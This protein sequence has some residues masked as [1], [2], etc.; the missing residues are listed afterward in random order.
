MDE[1]ELAGVGRRPEAGA[2]LP[3]GGDGGQSLVEF[4]LVL[5]LLLVL[6]FGIIEFANA[7]RT[8]QIITTASREVV[9]QT[10]LPNDV[11]NA[12]SLAKDRLQASGLNANA[13]TIIVK[14]TAE[15]GTADTVTIQYPFQFRVFSR[16]LELM[17]GSGCG[18]RFTTIDLSST[19]VMRNE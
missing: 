18:S 2:G 15:A 10:V 12:D 19:A 17:C 16:V 8:S 11:S 4:V 5:P 14:R 6:L 3:G 7:W 1:R 9:R 13:A